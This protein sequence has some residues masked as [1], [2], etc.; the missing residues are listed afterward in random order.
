M[1]SSRL[2]RTTHSCIAHIDL[3]LSLLE[4][5]IK[6]SDEKIVVDNSLVNATFGSWKKSSKEKFML[7]KLVNTT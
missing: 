4:R 1:R 2:V 5:V 6:L 3:E 7:T